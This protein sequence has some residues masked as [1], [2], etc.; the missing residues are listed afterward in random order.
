[1]DLRQELMTCMEKTMPCKDF[2]A[3]IIMAMV[4]LHVIET[5]IRKTPNL[6]ERRRLINEFNKGKGT[7]EKGI[8]ALKKN[9]GR[10]TRE[11]D[12]Q[13]RRAVS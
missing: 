2:R 7:I 12:E 10:R 5:Q 8:R 9:A 4:G 13:S 1:M 6:E 11:S 3:T